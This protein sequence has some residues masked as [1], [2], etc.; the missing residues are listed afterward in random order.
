MSSEEL[1][2]FL[3]KHTDPKSPARHDL[4]PGESNTGPKEPHV[5]VGARSQTCRIERGA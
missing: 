4:S 1:S 5:L 3:Q 2:E